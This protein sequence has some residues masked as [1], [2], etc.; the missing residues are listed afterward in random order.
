MTSAVGQ[1]HFSKFSY[2]QVVLR[3]SPKMT[4]N[5]CESE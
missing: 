5:L 1:L 2:D 4:E 3:K